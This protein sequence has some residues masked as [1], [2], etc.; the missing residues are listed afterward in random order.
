MT[1]TPITPLHLAISR[2]A[3]EHP[4]APAVLGL[5]GTVLSYAR[6]DR[7]ADAWARELRRRGVRA[8][9]LVPVLMT[10][11]P[12]LPPALLAIL[13]CG[14][15]YAALDHR[16]PDARIADV[17]AKLGT[18][19]VVVGPDHREAAERLGLDVWCPPPLA[20]AGAADSDD[21][22]TVGLEHTDAGATACVFFTSG[23][24]GE[25]KGVL[26][27]H[28][29]TMRLFDP[30]GTMAFTPG[31]VTPLS[32]YLT[33]DVAA[34]ELW[35][36]LTSGGTCV[37]VADDFLTPHSV[38]EL[39][40][41]Q[42]VN[43]LWLTTSLFHLLVDEDI[44]CFTGLHRLYVGGE[45]MS[46][47]HARAFLRRHPDI[48]F[49]NCY[50][51]VEVCMVVTTHRVTL[52]DCDD[53]RGIPL[54]RVVPYTEILV[55]DGDRRCEPGEPGEMCMAGAGVARGYLADDALTKAK[56]T[57]VQ[58]GDRSVR[59]YR[60]GD[61]GTVDEQGRHFFLGRTDRQIKLRGHR[62]ELDG[63]EAEVHAAAPGTACAVVALTGASGG[64]E[65]LA[66]FYARP[67][68]AVDHGPDPLHLRATLA[69]RLPGYS[70]PDT[71]VALD[72]LPLNVN[73]KID[74]ATLISEHW[75]SRQL[76]L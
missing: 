75:G 20:G 22:A 10:R 9:D 21:Q 74:R 50:G 48:E 64:Y 16:W 37:P 13:K 31:C 32:T 2:I 67:P 53:E 27:P 70:V 63:I 68:D 73:G 54:G 61:M 55:M 36:V 38:T 12:E 46:P 51:P 47:E 1:R 43:T 56:F 42:G 52:A 23:T 45:R 39:I 44:D 14:A 11:S 59:V 69:T 72:R 76:Q 17:L 24:T 29:A 62:V 71:V 18:S 28:S 58:D 3:A 26:S 4:D 6:L 8:G 15:A 30:T 25:S 5:D 49:Y 65:H 60:G 33:W 66:L 35:G 41:V 34:F 57:E 40:E 7:A 19:P